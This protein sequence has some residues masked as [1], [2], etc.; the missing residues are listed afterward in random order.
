TLP[1]VQAWNAWYTSTG[2]R[3]EGVARLRSRVDTACAEA[4]RDP[5]T[6]E[7]T[8]AVLVQLP[9]GLGRR[10]GGGVEPLR[11]SAA[12]LARSLRAFAGEGIAHVQLVLDPIN[13]HSIEEI[14]R[15]LQLLDGT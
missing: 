3:P 14:G 7:R 6:V 8:L 15:V 4:G 2:N 11:G 5:A 1:Y 12:E 13:A 9:A 10:E